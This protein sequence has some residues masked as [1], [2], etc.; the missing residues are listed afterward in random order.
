MPFGNDQFL[1]KIE[2]EA[3]T[4]VGQPRRKRP[5]VEVIDRRRV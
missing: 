4:I 1:E 3:A 5:G 2:K